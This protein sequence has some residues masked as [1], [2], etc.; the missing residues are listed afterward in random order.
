MTKR[1]TLAVK[2]EYFDAIR[3]GTK[4]HEFRLVNDYWEKRLVGR[5]YDE[6]EITKGYPAKD[7]LLRRMVFPYRGYRTRRLTHPHFGDKEVHVFA[8]PVGGSEIDQAKD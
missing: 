7:D 3:D 8:L 2:S 1:L 6:I 4:K 5:H